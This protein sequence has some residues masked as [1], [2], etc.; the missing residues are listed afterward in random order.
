MR[1]HATLFKCFVF[2]FLRRPPFKSLIGGRLKLPS[3]RA[4]NP[5]SLLRCEGSVLSTG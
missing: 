1:A 3:V 2:R 4:W 5:Y